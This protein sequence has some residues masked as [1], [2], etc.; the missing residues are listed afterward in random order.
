M[1]DEDDRVERANAGWQKF[2]DLLPPGSEPPQRRAKPPAS[3]AAEDAKVR[4]IQLETEKER[5]AENQKQSEIRR[6]AQQDA[7][8][9]MQRMHDKQ[10][11]MKL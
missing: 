8:E 10:N 3:D 2:L 6:K 1:A 9:S 4:A 7:F 11:E 5:L